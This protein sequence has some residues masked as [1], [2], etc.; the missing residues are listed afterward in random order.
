MNEPLRGSAKTDLSLINFTRTLNPKRTSRASRVP[1]R[2]SFTRDELTSLLN[3]YGRNVSNG[4]WCDYAMDFLFDRALFSIYRANSAHAL[5]TIEKN[6]K[7]RNKQGQ[8][9]VT[10]RQGRVL[11]RGHQL[12]QVLRVLDPGFAV[13][14]QG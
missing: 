3:L 2:I 8:Y 9:L 6:P 11:K 5:Y 7:L 4:V 13:V 1:E 10:N 14:K 12:V